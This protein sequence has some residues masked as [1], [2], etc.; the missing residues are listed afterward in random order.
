MENFSDTVSIVF[1][2]SGLGVIYLSRFL[3]RKYPKVSGN[4]LKSFDPD[5]EGIH[6]TYLVLNTVTVGLVAF[7][8]FLVYQANPIFWG[9]RVLVLFIPVFAVFAMFDGLFALRTKVFPTTTKHNWN[10]F[11][12]DKDDELRWVALWQIGLSM[13]L[14][15]IDYVAFVYSL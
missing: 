13:V 14:L 1:M 5:L 10:S 9:S 7:I 6:K 4:E 12:Y 15:A 8:L 11:V 2:L 3:L